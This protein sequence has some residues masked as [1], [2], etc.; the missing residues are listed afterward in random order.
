MTCEHCKDAKSGFC[1]YCCETV[2]TANTSLFKRN[3]AIMEEL[4]NLKC[5]QCGLWYSKCVDIKDFISQII[6]SKDAEREEALKSQHKAI[7]KCIPDAVEIDANISINPEE[8]LSNL[9]KAGL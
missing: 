2:C 4:D 1:E 5:P 6:E 7:L 8:L 9:K 3:E